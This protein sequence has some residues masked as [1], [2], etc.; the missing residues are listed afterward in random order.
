[1]G[2][3]VSVFR[4]VDLD[5]SEEDVKVT[6]GEVYGWHI[7]NDSAGSLFVRLYNATAANTT[8]GTTTPVLTI[9]V[10]AGQQSN[11]VLDRPIEFTTA[12]CAAATTGPGDS[13]TGAPGASECQINLFYK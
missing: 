11:V 3:N 4:S 6:G 13:D 10:G 9:G 8:V 2:L 7:F 5:E 1:M 12:I